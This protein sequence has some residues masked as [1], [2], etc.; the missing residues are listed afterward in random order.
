MLLSTL[1]FRSQK[2]KNKC[3][4]TY[5]CDSTFITRIQ[6]RLKTFALCHTVVFDISE[7]IF[8]MS[9]Q[10]QFNIIIINAQQFQGK[11]FDHK[12]VNFYLIISARN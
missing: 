11:M 12:I 1:F 5:L 4:K 8:S 9:L 7:F 10:I 2:E 6:R 3:A